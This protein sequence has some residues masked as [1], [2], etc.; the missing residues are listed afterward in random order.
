[1]VEAY[2][3][4]CNSNAQCTAALEALDADDSCINALNNNDKAT[5]CSGSC[6]DLINAAL[7]ACPNVS[8]D[9]YAYVGIAN[10]L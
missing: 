3:T 9:I 7:N 5:Y 10:N 6:A 8:D 2:N 1:M 4:T